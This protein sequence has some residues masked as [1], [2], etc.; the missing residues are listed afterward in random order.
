MRRVGIGRCVSLS[1]KL[2]LTLGVWIMVR[3]SE[4]VVTSG[5]VECEPNTYHSCYN[6]QNGPR[7]HCLSK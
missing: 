1:S 2:R 7:T 4:T 3:P 6:A 5:R